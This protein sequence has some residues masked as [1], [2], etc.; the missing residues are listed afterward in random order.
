MRRIPGTASIR[1]SCRLPSSSVARML[2]PVVLPLGRASEFTSPSPTISS[3][4]ATIG[5]RFRRLLH[6][7]NC[8]A[9]ASIDDIDPGFDQL[10]RILRNQ[11]DVRRKCAIIDREVLAFNE[12]AA[13]QF[14]EKKSRL[15]AHRAETET[16][17][18]DDRSAPLAA[19]RRERPRSGRA[20]EK[21][22]ELAP[23][24]GPSLTPR[25][26]PYHVVEKAP[27]SAGGYLLARL[28]RLGPA[29]EVAQIGAAIG[30]EFSHS[31]LT[32]V[33]RK[34]EIDINS[35]L[36]RLFHAGLLFRQG[37]PPHTTYLFKH[38]LVQDAAY[39]TLLREPRRALHARIAETLEGQFADIAESQRIFRDADQHSR[40]NQVCVPGSVPN[41]TTGAWLSDRPHHAQRPG[42]D[43]VGFRIQPLVNA[44]L[45]CLSLGLSTRH[46]T[47]ELSDCCP[48]FEVQPP[49]LCRPA[50]LVGPQQFYDLCFVT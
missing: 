15:K 13:S 27:G 21:G 11:I 22:D 33:A 30:R 31:L 18:P 37:V 5:M 49:I 20:A 2:T 6:G 3:A 8:H 25:T 7:A 36:D 9:P 28:D 1:M 39:G 17:N 46:S 16:S 41:G 4:I 42:A 29:K 10:R 45:E 35:A 14:V 50:I 19:P 23:S 48:L 44:A 34:P 43:G 40:C 26:T 12:T 32:A 24:H 47:V 38:A